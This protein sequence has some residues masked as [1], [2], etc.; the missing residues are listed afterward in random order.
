[1]RGNTKMTAQAKDILNLLNSGLNTD[2]ILSLGVGNSK[3]EIDFIVEQLI[4][5]GYID[6]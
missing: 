3:F 2:Q 6:G 4:A 1:M 5:K